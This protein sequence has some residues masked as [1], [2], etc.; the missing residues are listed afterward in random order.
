M[1]EIDERLKGL[2][3]EERLLTKEMDRLR[4]RFYSEKLTADERMA[5]IQCMRE[6]SSKAFDLLDALSTA[7]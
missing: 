1:K 7:E 5:L 6:L 2:Y 4:K 3:K